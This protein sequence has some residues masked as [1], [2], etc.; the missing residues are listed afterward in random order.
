MEPVE[1]QEALIEG[2]SPSQSNITTLRGPELIRKLKEVRGVA[3]YSGH[4]DTPTS[5]AMKKMHNS[6]NKVKD[7]DAMNDD[8]EQA[9]KKLIIGGIFVVAIV[10][11]LL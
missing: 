8:P 9:K 7:S 5:K 1:K 11:L 2:G 6:I 10:Y 3:H 4:R